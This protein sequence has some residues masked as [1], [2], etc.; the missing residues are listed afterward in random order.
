MVRSSHQHLR[1][2]SIC[3]LCSPRPSQLYGLSCWTVCLPAE[4]SSICHM[5]VPVVGGKAV[6]TSRLPLVA[7][8]LLS[9]LSGPAPPSQDV[10]TP[11]FLVPGVSTHASL[12]PPASGKYRCLAGARTY[13]AVDGTSWSC[14]LCD[15]TGPVAS[16]ILW[17]CWRLLAPVRSGSG[18]QGV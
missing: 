18:G 17:Y 15:I 2:S 1:L 12:Y 10:P 11:L 9:S 5:Y 7:M 16:L 13:V 8:C 3:R 14:W 6:G 4:F